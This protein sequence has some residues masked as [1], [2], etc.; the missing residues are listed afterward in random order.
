MSYSLEIVKR[1][2]D[3]KLLIDLVNN[4][5][6]VHNIFDGDELVEVT[7]SWNISYKNTENKNSAEYELTP[8]DTQD[9]YKFSNEEW[10]DLYH[11]YR[12][13]I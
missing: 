10:S 4:A 2:S 8:I 13:L 11:Y 6:D 1:K 12:K 7:K 9:T 3:G 5:C